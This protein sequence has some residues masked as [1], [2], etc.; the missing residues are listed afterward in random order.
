M[1]PVIAVR[2]QKMGTASAAVGASLTED[3][4]SRNVEVIEGIP[5]PEYLEVCVEHDDHVSDHI[6]GARPLNI[7]QNLLDTRKHQDIA[8]GQPSS[9]MMEDSDTTLAKRRELP[10]D[11]RSVCLL[12]GSA[13][14]IEGPQH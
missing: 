5:G 10:I 2:R 14:Q 6:N 8:V 9:F 1:C 12:N 7:R 13:C 4:T 11:G 3:C